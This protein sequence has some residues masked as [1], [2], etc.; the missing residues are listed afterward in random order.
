LAEIRE[1]KAKTKDDWAPHEANKYFSSSRQ[2]RDEVYSKLDTYEMGDAEV[3]A[4]SAQNN[5]RAISIVETMSSGRARTRRKIQD[6]VRRRHLTRQGKS[7]D[8]NLETGRQ[9]P[10]KISQDMDTGNRVGS[11]RL[12]RD[13]ARQS[14]EP[15]AALIDKAGMEQLSSSR[16]SQQAQVHAGPRANH[17]DQDKLHPCQEVGMNEDP[18]GDGPDIHDQITL[19]QLISLEEMTETT[20]GETGAHHHGH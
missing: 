4:R 3:L 8:L 7:N 9:R 12:H 5:I 14:K 15:A 16:S 10:H 17:L 2:E 19:P 11:D 18:H 13:H 1:N 20:A 6:E